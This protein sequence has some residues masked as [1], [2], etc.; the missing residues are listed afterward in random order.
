MINIKFYTDIFF[1]W[2]L[3]LNKI[4]KFFNK[5]IDFFDLLTLK[6]QKNQLNNKF[7]LDKSFITDFDNKEF[8][9]DNIILNYNIKSFFKK[10]NIKN[11][12]KTKF[13]FLNFQKIFP[14][15]LSKIKKK[16]I[17]FKIKKKL[18]KKINF[19]KKKNLFLRKW[20][21]LYK[22]SNFFKIITKENLKDYKYMKVFKNQNLNKNIKIKEKLDLNIFKKKRKK[23]WKK[24]FII[25]KS[26]FFS[27]KFKFYTIL[28][29]Y[30]KKQNFFKD[31]APKYFFGKYFQELKARN[32]WADFYS[33]N[34]YKF[35][36]K[37]KSGFYIIKKIM[38]IFKKKILFNDF[39]H[40]MTFL[41]SKDPSIDFLIKKSKRRRLENIWK[42]FKIKKFNNNKNFFSKFF[43][44]PRSF[45][46][47]KQLLFMGRSRFFNLKTTVITN[48][49]NIK[50]KELFSL[51]S[52]FLPILIKNKK[53]NNSYFF[54]VLSRLYLINLMNLLIY[55][56][57]KL[58][59]KNQINLN[60]V[61]FKFFCNFFFN[62]TLNFGKGSIKYNNIFFSNFFSK[63]VFL[64][65]KKSF[66]IGDKKFFFILKNF[67]LGFYNFFIL[68]HK[69]KKKLN[70]LSP[71]Y[72]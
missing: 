34:I 62:L 50:N 8:K 52:L 71:K 7:F 4:N 56:N 26:K 40:L 9:K 57:K 65:T 20:K 16:N 19:Y 47:L 42:I 39:F 70:Y 24:K 64:N 17:Y 5:F 67:Y 18:Q 66:R 23:K 33:N 69:R 45:D 38:K 58:I 6:D 48:Y 46:L 25:I 54:K 68:S 21:K 35:F 22:I 27:T 72:I 11:F 36:V 63:F 15:F 28:K 3:N 14:F 49:L 53:K 1:K 37:K 30:Y 13:F 41:K 31:P 29:N 61:F 32:L 51:K 55:I 2:N 43:S 60:R 44:F 59:I 10:L 12:F